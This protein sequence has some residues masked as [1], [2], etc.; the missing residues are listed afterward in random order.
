MTAASDACEG[1]RTKDQQKE[2]ATDSTVRLHREPVNMGLL[3]SGVLLA[4]SQNAMDDRKVVH[5][6]LFENP[7]FQRMESRNNH[8]IRDF[9]TCP[10]IR[11]QRQSESADLDKMSISPR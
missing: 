9:V 8:R 10:E 11:F 4:G 3:Y 6:Q 1:Q 2:R 5:A 7:T